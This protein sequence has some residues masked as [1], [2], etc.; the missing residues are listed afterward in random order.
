MEPDT[1]MYVMIFAIA[2]NFIVHLIVYF[3]HSIKI[4]IR[5]EINRE[6][7]IRILSE[8]FTPPIVFMVLSRR[9]HLR[10][11][12][13]HSDYTFIFYIWF[14]IVVLEL[15][16]W[17]FTVNKRGIYV[18]SGTIPFYKIRAYTWYESERHSNKYCRIG[19]KIY[20]KTGRRSSSYRQEMY[21]L[22]PI[23]KKAAM[24][25]FLENK[26]RYR[27]NETFESMTVK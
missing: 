22:V 2:L 12:E 9:F 1:F 14:F 4:R 25:E 6:M 26:V 21:Y 27:D 19:F 5:N 17:Q 23:D 3:R 15:W 13:L 20:E 18:N 16:V 24:D 7:I 8:I 10:H 11:I